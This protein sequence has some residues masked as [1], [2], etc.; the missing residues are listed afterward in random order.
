MRGG[1]VAVHA[2]QDVWGGDSV[3]LNI[4]VT[5]VMP[6]LN[7]TINPKRTN[8]INANLDTNVFDSKNDVGL[9]VEKELNVPVPL[10][11]IY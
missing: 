1:P 2:A 10:I 4:L 6:I 11:Y 3:G 9:V 8:N 5:I 7:N